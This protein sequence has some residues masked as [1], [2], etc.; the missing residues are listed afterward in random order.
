MLKKISDSIRHIRLWVCGLVALVIL[1][2][3]DIGVRRLENIPGL[4]IRNEG[5]STQAL[6]YM[7]ARMDRTPSPRIVWLGASVMQGVNAATPQTTAPVVSEKL[8]RAQNIPA[9]CFNTATIGNNFGDNLAIFTES[10]RHKPDLF[11]YAINIVI[12]SNQS[13][14]GKMCL[15]RNLAYY[16]RKEPDF[17]SLCQNNIEMGPSEWRRI[18]VDMSISRVWAFY[19]YSGLIRYVLTGKGE[20]M[21]EI[22][23]DFFSDAL[24]IKEKRATRMLRNILHDYKDREDL[25]KDLP[26]NFYLTKQG[27]FSDLDLDPNGVHCRTLDRLCKAAKKSGK[28]ILFFFNPMN[29]EVLDKFGLLEPEKMSQFK[30]VVL[31]LTGKYGFDSFDAT[32]MIPPKYF[33]DEIHLSIRG[34]QELAK[35]L[36]PEIERE[37]RLQNEGSLK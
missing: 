19:R 37:L 22:F 24:G 1:T 30:K 16:L 10:L 25:W 21:G 29:M 33:V 18:F 2:A 4:M 9:T 17:L 27:M 7:F 5:R 35:I 28:K 3:V 31:S 12:F 13:I 20:D 6:P 11:V 23:E 8:L 14:F 34:H 32:T 36:A 26:D 15:Q